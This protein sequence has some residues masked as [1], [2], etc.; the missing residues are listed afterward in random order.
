MDI[1]FSFKDRVTGYVDIKKKPAEKKL[2][3]FTAEEAFEEQDRFVFLPG[4]S[5]F[6]RKSRDKYQTI[7]GQLADAKLCRPVI[8]K[9][10]IMSKTAEIGN[11][12]VIFPGAIVGKNVRIGEGCVVNSGAIIEH[13]SSVQMYSHIAPGATVCGNVHIGEYTLIGAGAT[14]VN[15]VYVE[16]GSLVKA[17]STVFA[18]IS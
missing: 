5:Y 4:L 15:S 6:D 9:T 7:I 13:D 3:Y 17:G 2:T 1:R 10:A 12:T 8:D 11:G 18:G 16:Q 14:V